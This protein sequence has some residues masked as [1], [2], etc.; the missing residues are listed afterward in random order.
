MNEERNSGKN[1]STNH[2]IKSEGD[3]VDRGNQSVETFCLMLMFRMR[4]PKDFFILRAFA[5]YMDSMMGVF[6][7][8]PICALVSQRIFCM[9]GGLSPSFEGFDQLRDL[10]LPFEVPDIS[11]LVTDILWCD[12][13]RSVAGYQPNRRGVS[14]VFGE[15]VVQAFCEKYN[16][17][18]IARAHQNHGWRDSANL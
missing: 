9:H 14:Y 7:H 15:D 2:R 3:Y 8:L 17:D 18:L 16:I 13:D 10:K 5:A 12:P 4:Y 6:A 11:S 1:L